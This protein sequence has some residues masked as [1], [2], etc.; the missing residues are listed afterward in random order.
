MNH[1]TLR[2]GMN[3][4]NVVDEEGQSWW[5]ALATVLGDGSIA[6]SS[7]RSRARMPMPCP[8]PTITQNQWRA[9]INR[10]IAR[11]I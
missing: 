1:L 6:V 3:H 10:A 2:P 5:Q 9:L 8:G 7:L 4:F 11:I